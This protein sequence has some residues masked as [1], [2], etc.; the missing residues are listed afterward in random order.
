MAKK[1]YVVFGL[2]RFGMSVATA[3]ADSGCTVM[4][5]D[6]S[7]EKIQEI[8]ES[9]TYAVR[10]D[11]LDIESMNSLGIKNFDG[12]VVAI[13]SNME[14][15]I[16]VTILLKEIGVPYVLAKAQSELHEK[17]LKKL[18]ADMVV[19]PEKELGIR[20]ANNLIMGNFFDLVELSST[21]SMLEM[22]VLP[23]WEGQSLL[24]LNLRAKK[25]INVIGIKRQDGGITVNP[26]ANE[27]LESGDTLI[28]I[29]KN[30]KLNKLL[31][32]GHGR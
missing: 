29:G 28:V 1:E 27:R 18:G 19:Q 2:G 3:L 16:L 32:E 11:V 4:A 9:V 10:A 24:D 25:K 23:E 20:T 13:G 7:E 21:F 5:V 6:K 17:I 12:A 8:A 22:M 14:T 30:D 26:E 15:S 31:K